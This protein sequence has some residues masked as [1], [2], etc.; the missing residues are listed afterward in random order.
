MCIRDSCIDGDK[1]EKMFV[2]HFA[3]PF[4]KNSANKQVGSVEEAIAQS[5]EQVA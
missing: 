4:V 2:E 1:A 5:N 3:Y